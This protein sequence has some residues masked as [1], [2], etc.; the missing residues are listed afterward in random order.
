[1]SSLINY[2]HKPTKISDFWWHQCSC[3]LGYYKYTLY[4]YWLCWVLFHDALYRRNGTAKV[5]R[6]IFSYCKI[7]FRFR[8]KHSLHNGLD[9]DVS[10]LKYALMTSKL[11]TFLT[12]LNPHKAEIKPV[13]NTW[14]VDNKEDEDL[15]SSQMI[16]VEI[17]IS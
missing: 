15:L 12:K 7:I 11:C 5:W 9:F 17:R 16:N 6:V 8:K 1:M 14:Y 2:T 10:L 13:L 3:K 4:R